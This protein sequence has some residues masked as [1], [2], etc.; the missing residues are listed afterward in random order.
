MSSEETTGEVLPVN[1]DTLMQIANNVQHNRISL[2]EQKMSLDSL[3]QSSER[4][5]TASI[6]MAAIA[7]ERMEMDRES[8]QA[9]LRQAEEAAQSDRE[10]KQ[11]VAKWFNTNWRYLLVVGILIFYPQ[12]ITQM[13]YLGLLPAFTPAQAQQ[14]AAPMPTI[15]APIPVLPPTSEP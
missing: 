2:A 12:I 9:A 4:T 13:Q 15:P 10:A 7:K 3:M 14:L 6:E 1:A 11:M 8:R 5:A